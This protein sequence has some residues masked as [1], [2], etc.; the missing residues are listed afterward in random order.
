M[1]SSSISSYYPWMTWVES[2]VPRVRRSWRKKHAPRAYIACRV[3]DTAAMYAGVAAGVGAGFVDTRV[4]SEKTQLRQLRPQQED[5]GMDLWLLTHPDLKKSARVVLSWTW[6]GNEWVGR[7]R[8]RSSGIPPIAVAGIC[9]AL[10]PSVINPTGQE[11]PVPP[12]PQ[13]PGARL[14]VATVP[15]LRRVPGGAVLLQGPWLLSILRRTSHQPD[16][17]KPRRPRPPGRTR[18]PVGHR[19]SHAAALLAGEATGP[20]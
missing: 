14:H 1:V 5:F 8:T 3:N 13:Y 15:E 19:L 20:S 9:W 4:A 16:R 10:H 18:P 6:L 12:M 17:R 11:T 7:W 2:M